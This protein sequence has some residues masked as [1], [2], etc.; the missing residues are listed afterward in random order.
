MRK[1]VRKM[2]RE[3]A[4]KKHYKASKYVAYEWNHRQIKKCGSPIR[5]RN[6]CRGTH[7]KGLW[8]SRYFTALALQKEK[9]Q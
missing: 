1:Y 2:M 6:M 7:K 8:T 3:A 5:D 9:E 4:Q